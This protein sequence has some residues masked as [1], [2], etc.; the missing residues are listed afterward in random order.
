MR[1]LGDPKNCS[2]E[3]TFDQIQRRIFGP[4]GC[5]VQTCHGAAEAGGL[6]LRF[7][8]AHTSLVDVPAANAAAAATRKRRV[9][10]GDVDA[11]FLWQKVAGRLD[12]AE[13]ARMPQVGRALNDVELD[14]LR[15]WIEGGAPAGGY[16]RQAPCLPHDAFQAAPALTP[17]PGGHQIYFEGPTLQPGEEIEACM[18]LRVP[19]TED[20]AVGMWEYSL[21]PGTH[22]FALWEHV[23]PSVPELNVLKRDL[24]CVAGGARID[25]VTISASPEAP[26]FVDAYPPGVGRVLPGNSLIG[27]NPHYYNEFDVPVQIK[28]WINL[29]PVAGGMQHQSVNLVSTF[30][31]LGDTTTYSI[32]VPPYSRGTLRVRYTNT[33]DKP[34]SIFELTSHEHQRGIRF[35]ALALRWHKAVREPRLGPPADHPVQPAARPPSRRLHR[36]RV[37]ARQR[38]VPAHSPLRRLPR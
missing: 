29:H 21:N 38:R 7:G 15:T 2:G 13:G 26:Y 31:S 24:A 28:G 3:S 35:T 22:H 18:W 17:P 19:N 33:T 27:I 6:D 12:A 1:F 30:A 20:F 32:N 23:R 34:W 36:I 5:R 14:L 11:S 16:V 9:V 25:G 10:P 8:V 37:R 4:R